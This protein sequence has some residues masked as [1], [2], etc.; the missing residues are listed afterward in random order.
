MPSLSTARRIA[1]MKNNGAK[2]I[3]RIHK[4]NSDELMEMTWDND[5]QSK[6]CYIYDYFHDD[7][8]DKKDHMTY[9]NTT[10]TR[11]DAKFIVKTY[12]SLDKD[13][14]EYYLQFKP[15][16]PTEFSEGDELYYFEKE[17][18]DKYHN[19]D[20]IGL[21]CDIPD[22]KGI[23][24]KWLIVRKEIANQFVKY[25][26]IPCN[27]ELMWIERN[28]Q[29]RIKRRMWSALKMQ[30]SYNSG[31]WRD[32]NFASQENQNKCWLP[33]NS[34]TEK[35]W[36]T[37]DN[38][39]NMRVLVGAY[40]ENPIA[41]VI[42]KVENANNLGI[43]Q[44][45][46]YQDF[47]DQHRDYIERDEDGNIIG[48]WANYFDS[49]IAPT[50]PTEP[51]VISSSNYGT[52]T[53]STSTIKIGGSYKTL[54][55]TVYDESGTDITDSYSDAIFNWTCNIEGVDNTELDSAVT[56]L[57][58]TTFN[59]KKI[60]FSNDRSYLEK[61]LEVKCEVYKKSKTPTIATMQ[62]ELIV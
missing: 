12:Q 41:W 16:Q 51:I 30:S 2:T 6:L 27:F 17:Y 49:D 50:N 5:I 39:Q 57:D 4:E 46:L 53:A 35:I 10:K 23:Y 8:K 45:T 22:D 36:Y 38:A 29:E 54:T 55:A 34:I 58:G 25:L 61:I 59:K 43:Q 47:F 40:T 20:F 13:Q 18:R 52:I 24:R 33:L 37:S 7:Q 32:Y 44:L 60:K 19:E 1:S 3:G 11:I 42:S 26:V 14:V 62:F 56:W 15:S 9:E 31:I 48:L 28:G 21:Y